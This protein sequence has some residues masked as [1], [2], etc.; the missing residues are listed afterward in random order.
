MFSTEGAHNI[1]ATYHGTINFQASSGAITQVANNHTVQTGNQFCDPGAITI[2]RT[3][4]WAA[5][6]YPSNVLVTGLGNVG[7]VAVTL[8]NI[9]R[10]PDQRRDRQVK[11]HRYREWGTSDKRCGGSE[12]GGHPAQVLSWLKWVA[13]TRNSSNGEIQ[14]LS[15]P[16]K[17]LAA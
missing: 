2:P 16:R 9:R 13:I 15:Q 6:P 11:H 17:P 4:R 8:K 7:I 12:S 1:T 3:D 5:T 14:T 10:D